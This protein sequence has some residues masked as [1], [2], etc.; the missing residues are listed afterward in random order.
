M[1]VQEALRYS[2]PS[3]LTICALM[4][5]LSAVR[6]AAEEN[7]GTSVS[8]VMLAAV[9]DGLDGHVARYLEACTKLGFELDSLCDC[10]NFGVVPALVVF[11]W[12]KT[13]PTAECRSDRCVGEDLAL[14]VACCCY[15]ACCALRLARFNVA[16]HAAQMDRSYLQAAGDRRP[17]VPKAVLH[18]FL[19]RKLYFKGVPAPVAAA[20]AVAPM[21]LH[22]SATYRAVTAAGR[23]GAWAMGRRGTAAT[24]LIT[25][26]LMVSPL[27][28]LSSKM[29]K[30]AP[31]DSLLR[32]RS[33][34]RRLA[35]DPP[36]H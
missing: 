16:G 5:G 33:C 22:F 20:Y 26:V 8:C 27:P 3:A 2:V 30:T 36:C 21:M 35:K 28:T 15:C 19:Q 7:F 31:S 10:A 24:L 23:V 34:T 9:L 14:W 11:F 18:N 32:S 4:S 25:A 29:L 6:F 17:P 1:G 12:A 13:L